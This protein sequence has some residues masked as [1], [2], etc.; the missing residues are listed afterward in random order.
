MKGSRKESAPGDLSGR[1]KPD[2]YTA[3]GGVV[4]IATGI[5]EWVVGRSVLSADVDISF[6]IRADAG[7]GV[8]IVSFDA[9]GPGELVLIIELG[10]EERLCIAQSGG[11]W[12]RTC[13]H[14]YKNENPGRPGF[15]WKRCFA[16]G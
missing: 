1:I 5:F 10:N 11:G 14:R 16:A 6:F 7:V 15:R 3:G 9:G 8:V 4:K 13:C 2:Q 12:W